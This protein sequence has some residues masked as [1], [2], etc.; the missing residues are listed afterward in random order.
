MSANPVGGVESC[1]QVRR[2][3]KNFL[4]DI[5]KRYAGKKVIVV[6]HGEPLEQLYGLL[7]NESDVCNSEWLSNGSHTEVVWEF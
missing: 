2:R 1:V 5:Q 3:M 7:T 4:D 6:S